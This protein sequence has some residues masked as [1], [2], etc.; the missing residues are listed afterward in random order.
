MTGETL[1]T[2]LGMAVA[3]YATRAGGFWLMGR[4]TPTPRLTAWLRRLPQAIL[5]SIAAPMVL[6]KGPAEAMAGVVTVLVASRTRHLL[7]PISAG[8]IA[9]WVLRSVL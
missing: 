4:L 2:I 8:V 5:L 1:L 3:T 6:S 9:V 7:L